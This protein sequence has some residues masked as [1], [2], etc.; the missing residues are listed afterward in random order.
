VGPPG[1]DDAVMMLQARGA[2]RCVMPARRCV[3]PARRSEPSVCLTTWDARQ[4]VLVQ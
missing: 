3:M 4:A 1:G 2:W